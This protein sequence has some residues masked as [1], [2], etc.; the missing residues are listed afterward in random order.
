MKSASSAPFSTFG[1][2]PPPPLAWSPADATT[3]GTGRLAE[4]LGATFM[5]SRID[6]A[7]W[8]AFKCSDA[9]GRADGN[10]VAL[11]AGPTAFPLTA[12]P[13][14]RASDASVRPKSSLAK[15]AMQ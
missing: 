9:E 5:A 14:F 7:K 15:G 11:N 10:V 13:S 3:V 6:D 2:A 8:V 4:L 12:R 1:V